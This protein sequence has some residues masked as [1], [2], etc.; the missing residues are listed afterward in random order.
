MKR[1]L[2]TAATVL[3]ALA[4]GVSAQGVDRQPP[5]VSADEVDAAI[6][7]YVDVIYG[8]LNEQG[9]WEQLPDFAAVQAVAD[10]Q[11][12]RRHIWQWCGRTS[13]CVLA[14]LHA[15]EDPQ[16]PQLARAINFLCENDTDG[17]YATGIRCGVWSFLMTHGKDPGRKYRQF[18]ARDAKWLMECTKTRDTTGAIRGFFG[19]VQYVGGDHSNSQ[20]GVL[21]LYEAALNNIEIPIE[22]WQIIEKHYIDT[23]GDN[24]GWG[25]TT[26]GVP[27]NEDTYGSMTVAGLASMYIAFDMLTAASYEGKSARCCGRRPLPDAIEKAKAWLDRNL[28]ADFGIPGAPP[29][30]NQVKR[31]HGMNNYYIYGVERCG[32]ASGRKTFGGLNWFEVGARWLMNN[33]ARA[34]H[35]RECAASWA[36]LFL[37]KGRGPVFYNKLDTGSNDWNNNPRDIASLSRFCSDTLET[38]VN[39][40]IVDIK[41]PVESWLDAPC[42]FFN[43]QKLPKF[44]DEQKRKLRV[45]T[46]SGGTIVA[47]AGCS[48]KEFVN[49]F[50]TLAREVWPE[51]ELE[52]LLPDHPVMTAQYAIKERLPAIYHIFDGCRSRVWLLAEDMACAWAR[53]LR[54]KYQPFFQFGFNLPRYANDKRLVQNR[55]AFQPWEIDELVAQG[56][57]VP[58]KPETQIKLR[59]AEWPTE[60]SRRTDIR[61]LR[62][63]T[64]AL[65][66]DLNVIVEATELKDNNL[67]DLDGVNVV[68]MSG[69]FSFSVSD[70]N[71]AKLRAFIDRGGLIWADAQC[72]REAF[73]KSFVAFVQKLV[74]G[75]TL[76]DVA[77]DDPVRTGQGLGREGF[78]ETKVKYKRSLLFNELPKANLKEVR[79]DGRR[80]VIYSPY[81]IT[82]GLDGHDCYDCRGYERNDC[83]RLASNILLSVLPP[84]PVTPPEAT[85]AAADPDQ[86]GHEDEAD[87]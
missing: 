72:G 64:E 51:W 77:K 79:K 6:K 18:L 76:D 10:E 62:H 74:P 73:D 5:S 50:R 40:Q 63:L 82:C 26:Q 35:G 14:L 15:G 7:A 69:H 8:L 60:G 54:D 12:R 58:P 31:P 85:E 19:Y 56:K 80:V 41:D 49:D 46:D 38:R 23:L 81:D 44:T 39:W 2:W 71:L 29:G 27:V 30:D 24:G 25:Y 20:Y 9:H 48:K 3:L 13:L 52:R 66:E 75:A 21:G 47:E 34:E 65:R 59:L 87:Q 83:I 84:A 4:G 11:A 68:H 16:S 43:G 42:L 61:G 53:N 86:G 22:Y 33:Q 78:D 28:P 57:P 45:Y 55:L 36:L 70:E 37:C 32:S 17:T 67:G 1:L